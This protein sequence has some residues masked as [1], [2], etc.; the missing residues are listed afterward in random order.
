MLSVIY[1]KAYKFPQ[2]DIFLF[3]FYAIF[4]WL[5]FSAQK[6]RMHVINFIDFFSFLTF[7]ALAFVTFLERL[8]LCQ[9]HTLVF[10]SLFPLHLWSESGNCIKSAVN[11]SGHGNYFAD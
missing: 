5:F 2:F 6:I 7:I 11:N 3:I 4:L 1:C 10:S 8:F 9:G